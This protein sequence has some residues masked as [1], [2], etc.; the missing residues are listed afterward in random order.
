MKPCFKIFFL[1][2]L[3]LL[4]ASCAKERVGPSVPE[5]ETERVT[6]ELFT[7]LSDSFH[8]PVSRAADEWGVEKDPWVLVFK[9]DGSGLRENATFAEAAKTDITTNNKSYVS[10]TPRTEKCWVLILANPQAQFYAG[11][12]AY[13]FT[14]ANLKTVL[15]N[16][17]LSDA[18]ALL[19]AM[20]LTSGAAVNDPPFNTRKLP[21]SYLSESPLAGIRTGT[22]IGTSA[23]P[24]ELTRSV[25]KIVVK[26]TAADFTLLGI[27][28]LYR[29]NNRTLL[30][31][32]SADPPAVTDPVDYVTSDPAGYDFVTAAGNVSEA[33]YAYEAEGNSS[34][35]AYMIVRAE[36]NGQHCYYKMA[37]VDDNFTPIDLRRNY[38]YEF[39]VTGTHA[40]G[41]DTYTD[42]LLSVPNNILLDYTVKVTAADAHESV[43]NGE[44][45]LS[46]SNRLCLIYDDAGT[47]QYAAFTLTTNCTKSFSATSNRI[48]GTNGVS[49]VSPS[50]IPVAPDADS[51]VSADVIVRLDALGTGYVDLKL[52]N[53]EQT[54]TVI[55]QAAIPA[56]G[57]VLSY[58][59]WRTTDGGWWY[60]TYYLSTGHVQSGAG[61]TLSTT[62]NHTFPV[63]PARATAEDGKINIHVAAAGQRRNGLVWL[64][65]IKNPDFPEGDNK[66]I[67]R[68]IKVWLYQNGS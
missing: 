7:R 35:H 26:S 37:L 67:P 20:P 15:A 18:T 30:H 58:Y 11:E 57:A 45:Y 64:T 19:S 66:N 31:N 51:P 23:A 17:T 55:K 62:E 41:F 27:H 14:V 12:T 52:G 8:T 53:L 25:A 2:S 61:I 16:R 6:I 5:E 65:T 4:A 1:W 44:Y 59:D 68:R 50:S 46:V 10:L 21:M 32:L 36:Y 43:A 22:T 3:V 28:S 49:V 13:D 9:D 33:V 29:L 48:T 40:P 47:A 38:Q 39:T 54:V 63:D 24:L 34:D 60:F 56:S 42:A